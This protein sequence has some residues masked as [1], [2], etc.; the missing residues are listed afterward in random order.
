VFLIECPT[1]Q[2]VPILD[3]LAESRWT[4]LVRYRY[5]DDGR[6]GWG[7]QPLRHEHEYLS[8]GPL[9]RQLATAVEI[10]QGRVS[11]VCVFGHRGVARQSALLA[12]RLRRVP[13]VVRTD[14][15][16]FNADWDAAWLRLVRRLLIAAIVPRHARVWSIGT[17]NDYYWRTHARRNN[18]MRIPYETPVLPGG[19][20]ARVMH[21]SASTQFRFLYVGRLDSN[22]SVDLILSAFLDLPHGRQRYSLTLVGDGPERL[23]LERMAGHEPLITFSGS[24][25]YC[26][27]GTKYAGHDCL[28]L[29]SRRE[30]WGLVVNEAL[31]FGL[32]VIVADSVGAAHD[33]VD[34]DVGHIVPYGDVSA[35]RE[36]MVDAAQRGRSRHLRSPSDTSPLM[37]QELEALLG[38][39]GPARARVPV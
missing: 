5:R 15:N 39:P 8:E 23:S 3:R 28:I 2:R 32:R 14:S 21:K 36:A 9:L 7:T 19:A 26:E 4:L 17:A 38:G 33:L 11:V 35:L 6:H 24:V 18:I 29:A 31:A 27:L 13:V 20:E 34:D 10:L 16:G 1:P 30:P 37:R 22:K 12:A 25:R